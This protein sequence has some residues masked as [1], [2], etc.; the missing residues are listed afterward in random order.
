MWLQDQGYTGKSSMIRAISRFMGTRSVAAIGKDSMHNQ[1]GYSTVYGRRLAVFGDNKNPKLL[2]D[3]KIHSILGGDIVPIERKN[4]ATFSAPI[5]A[6]LLIGANTPPEVDLGA[7][8]EVTRI[9]YIPLQEPPESVLKGFCALDE[10]G[11]VKRQKEGTPVYVGGNLE[12]LLFHEIHFF[13]GT[14]MGDYKELCPNRM[15]IAMTEEMWDVLNSRCPSPEHLGIEKFVGSELTFGKGL[16]TDPSD[17]MAAYQEF[18]KLNR[19]TSFDFSR[20]KTYLET[21][22]KV[23]NSFVGGVRKMKGVSIGTSQ[24]DLPEPVGLLD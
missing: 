1:F 16:S 21:R 3:S 11:N 17:M 5:H 6:K 9:L 4:I 12:D 7:R 18:N 10:H 13:L 22:H 20:L 19:S 15:D 8:S 2:H 24:A 14:C 23:T